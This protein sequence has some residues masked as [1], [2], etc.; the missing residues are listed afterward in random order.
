MAA[1]LEIYESIH[2]LIQEYHEA[3][4]IARNMK[5]KTTDQW[6]NILGIDHKCSLG[7]TEQLKKARAR[8]RKV[9]MEADQFRVNGYSE[10]E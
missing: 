2:T 5:F 7:A 6:L 1:T 8:L 4:G 9:K 10:I 3:L